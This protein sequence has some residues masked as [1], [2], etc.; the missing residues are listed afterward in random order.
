MHGDTAI[1]GIGRR[2]GLTSVYAVFDSRNCEQ[3]A[4]FH[5]FPYLEKALSPTV[6]AALV[7]VTGGSADIN[8]PT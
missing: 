4:V 3:P 6:L 1:E 5:R 7:T 8:G 2:K